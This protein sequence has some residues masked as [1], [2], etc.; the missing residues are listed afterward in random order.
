MADASNLRPNTAKEKTI[1]KGFIFGLAALIPSVVAYILADSLTM[2]S[3]I[4]RSTSET[5]SIF[6]SWIVVRRIKNYE[7]ETFNYGLGKF[8]DLVS[9]VVSFAMFLSVYIIASGA[10]GRLQSPESIGTVGALIGIAISLTAGT[11]NIHLWRQNYMLCKKEFSSVLQSQWRLFRS[12][13]FANATVSTTLILSLLFRNFDWSLYVDPFGSFVIS[14]FILFS[15]FKIIRSSIFGLLDQ[16]LEESLQFVILKVL[17]ENYD[18]YKFFN[19]I[20]SRRSGGEV[21]ID[22]ALDFSEDKTVAGVEETVNSIKA[23]LE[24]RIANSHV[25]VVLGTF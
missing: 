22:I 11:I 6:L 2:L 16:T 9:I 24:S 7:K 13:A 21:Y 14:G 4:I 20:R 19:G 15:A 25:A 10:I 8:E 1:F 23:S 12:K 17:A 3:G 18:D 5:I